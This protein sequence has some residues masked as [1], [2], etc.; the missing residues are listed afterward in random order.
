MLNDSRLFREMT[1]WA[2]HLVEIGTH[3]VFIQNPEAQK[4]SCELAGYV[5]AIELTDLN[6]TL[7]CQPNRSSIR[8]SQQKPSITV[9]ATIRGKTLSLINLSLQSDKVSTSISEKIEIDGNTVIAQ[10]MQKLFQHMEFDWEEFL[11]GK[12]GDIPAYYL[13]KV[14]KNGTGQLKENI[15]S[16]KTTTQEFLQYEKPVLPSVHEFNSFKQDVNSLRQSV[17]RLEALIELKLS[18][19]NNK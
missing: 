12:I 13:S 17:E 19:G 1:Q 10:K 11:S 9:S 7:Y 6:I 14:I 8:I 5:V 18:D 3:E 4:M 15:N 16:L 2:L